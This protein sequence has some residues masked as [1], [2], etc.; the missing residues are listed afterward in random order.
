MS[1]ARFNHMELTLPPGS[2]DEGGLR[3]D[4]TRFYTEVFG[5]NARDVYIVKQNALL[6]ATDREVSQFILLTQMEK[7]MQSP[8]YDHLG[9]LLDTRAEVDEA[10]ERCRKFQERDER[11]QLKLYEDLENP[12]FLVHAF[13]VKYLLPIWFDVQCMEYKDD[14]SRPPLSWTYA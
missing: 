7:H 10:L 4:I 5:W 3:Q 9:L 2:L 12:N 6:L 8:G 14:A 1:L 13:Y 11:V